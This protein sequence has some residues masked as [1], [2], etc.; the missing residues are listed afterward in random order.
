MLAALPRV[1]K[2]DKG[3]WTTAFK[4]IWVIAGGDAWKYS[5]DYAILDSA[6]DIYAP[7]PAAAIV[8]LRQ[9]S[10]LYAQYS[11]ASVR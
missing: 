4:R 1:G 5:E 9:R 6:H 11:R 2:V 3:E 8:T 10:V 7:L